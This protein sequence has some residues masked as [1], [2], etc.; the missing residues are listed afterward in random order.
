MASS[1]ARPSP[2]PVAAWLDTAGGK[3]LTWFATQC[4][5]AVHG[6]LNASTD[7]PHCDITHG[8]GIRVGHNGTFTAHFRVITGIVGD[9][10]CGTPGHTTCVIGVGTAQGA[11]TVVHHLLQGP[12]RRR[13]ERHHDHRLTR[14]GPAATQASC[15]HSRWL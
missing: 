9:G 2:S 12:A 1:A 3:P 10:Y 5:A 8:R 4:T 13:R 11:G 14:Q 6:H 15:S 7:T